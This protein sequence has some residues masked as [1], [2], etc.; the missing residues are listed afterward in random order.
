MNRQ[1]AGTNKTRWLSIIYYFLFIIYYLLFLSIIYYSSL[2][3]MNRQQAGTNKTR[4]LSIIRRR[5]Q[6][7]SRETQNIDE[8]YPALTRNL[9]F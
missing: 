7:D 4:W 2:L 1:G 8:E 5:A 3:R 6:R 9:V